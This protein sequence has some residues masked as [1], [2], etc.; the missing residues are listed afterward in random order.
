MAGG[1]IT[2]EKGLLLVANRRRNGRVDWSTPGGVVDDG[3]TTLD[4]LTREVREE[5]GL[6]V[7]RWSRMCW[8]TEVD[9]VDL[10]THLAVEVHLADGFEGELVVEDPDGIVT[11]AAFVTGAAAAERLETSPP[12]V[13]EPTRDWLAAPWDER[14][15]FAY[16]ALGTDPASMRTERLD[17]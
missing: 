14:R 4:A 17:V 12:W 1:L 13:A 6:V 8:T 15:H 7:A 5:T 2:D 11:D 16:R 9:F 10:D 3:E